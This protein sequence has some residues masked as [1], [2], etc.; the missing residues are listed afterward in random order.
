MKGLSK[1]CIVARGAELVDEL[2]DA[3]DVGIE[4][5]DLQA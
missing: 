1:G 2:E 3:L 5:E 4:L